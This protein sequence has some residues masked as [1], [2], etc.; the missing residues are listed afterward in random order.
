LIESDAMHYELLT[1][2]LTDGIA[3]LEQVL[4][5]VAMQAQEMQDEIDR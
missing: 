1:E 2:S 3:E 5:L 4:S